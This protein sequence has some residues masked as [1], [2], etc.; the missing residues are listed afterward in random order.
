[1]SKKKDYSAPTP[2]ATLGAHRQ[3]LLSLRFSN[4]NERDALTNY[5][6]KTRSGVLYCVHCLMRV[7]EVTFVQVAAQHHYVSATLSTAASVRKRSR[8]ADDNDNT[9]TTTTT[10][11]TTLSNMTNSN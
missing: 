1:M 3:R 7:D 5:V 10:T 4:H 9:D 11:A 2:L 6:F 8:T